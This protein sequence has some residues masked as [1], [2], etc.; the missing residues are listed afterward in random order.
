MSDEVDEAPPGKQRNLVREKK[1]EMA[2]AKTLYRRARNRGVGTDVGRDVRIELATAL[3]NYYD[4][5][6]E[7]AD[8]D[9]QVKQAWDEYEM[10]A[11][12][13]L[14]A[15][16]VEVQAPTPGDTS[17]TQT[18]EESA[19]VVQD[20]EQLVEWSKQLDY[21]AMQLGLGKDI[22]TSRPLGRVGGAERYE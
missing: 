16:T 13:R 6:W 22:D 1:V 3:A 10:D 11:I 7:Y 5:V 4:A 20:P 9:Q 15:S 2:E 19:L 21:L 8:Q 14:D 18:V 17:A 12:A